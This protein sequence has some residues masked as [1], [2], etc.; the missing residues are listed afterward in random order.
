[1]TNATLYRGDGRYY[2]VPD[3]HELVSGTLELSTV[4][5]STVRVDAAAVAPFR[6]T[7]AIAR[8]HTKAQLASMAAGMAQLTAGVARGV[9]ALDEGSPTTRSALPALE[10]SLARLTERLAQADLTKV[11]DYRDVREHMGSL[12]RLGEVAK[13][14]AVLGEA[15]QTLAELFPPE[16][17]E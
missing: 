12:Q 3:D 15:Q 2:L 4:Q 9:S 17:E 14:E 11:D 10:A 8:A 6:V 5:G 13:L 1:L 7:E 16:G